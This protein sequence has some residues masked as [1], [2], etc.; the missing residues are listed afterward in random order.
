MACYRAADFFPVFPGDSPTR[1]FRVTSRVPHENPGF[2][3]YSGD[4]MSAEGLGITRGTA[5]KPADWPLPSEVQCPDATRTFGSLALVG[6]AAVGVGL[7][8][9]TTRSKHATSQSS[10]SGLRRRRRWRSR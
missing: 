5:V 4:L 7:F 1:L 6:I 9:W 3:V 8:F 10:F 2:V